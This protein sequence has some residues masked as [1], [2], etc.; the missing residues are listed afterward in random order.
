[1]I[2]STSLGLGWY[3]SVPDFRDYVFPGNGA[4]SAMLERLKTAPSDRL[5]GPAKVDLRE[6]FV[7]VSDQQRIKASTAHAC[8]DLVQY[9]ERR[10]RGRLVAPSRLFLY[11]MTRTLLGVTG[12]TGVDLRTA[13]KAIVR[14][15][16]PPEQLWPYDVNTFDKEPGAY[17][18]SFA[19]E[20]ES[21]TYLRL[22]ARNA[23]GAQT[24]LTVRAFLAAGFPS[25]FGFCVP[26]SLNGFPDVPYRCPFD[27]T[28]GGQAV[29]AV[30]YDDQRHTA[31]GNGAL[32]FRNSWGKQWGEGG[33]GWLPYVYVEEQLATDFWTLLKPEWVESGEFSRPRLP[34]RRLGAPTFAGECIGQKGAE[35]FLARLF[36]GPP[37]GGS[38]RT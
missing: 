1:M 24:L 15:G 31:T 14:F 13:L 7:G 27:R 37:E 36:V 29:V 20:T 35:C 10:A 4:V 34:G 28:L 26:D 9:F 12:D 21:I 2:G 22:D 32:L 33:Y 38:G 17:L 30:G 16:L 19:N 5:C 11:K 3:P 18:F 23:S 8:A 6:Y 25:V